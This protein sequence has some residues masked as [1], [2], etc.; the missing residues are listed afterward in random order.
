MFHC[1][2]RSLPNKHILCC[3]EKHFGEVFGRSPLLLNQIVYNCFVHSSAWVA[4]Q[5]SWFSI[6][7]EK[8]EA[9]FS[10]WNLIIFMKK[11]FAILISK[12]NVKALNLDNFRF[13]NLTMK[14]WKWIHPDDINLHRNDWI[15]SCPDF[16]ILYWNNWIWTCQENH[17]WLHIVRIYFIV[18]RIVLHPSS[19]RIFLYA[20]ISF[21]KLV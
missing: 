11:L 1:E 13:Q 16:R 2:S 6:T 20:S 5:L 21:Y 15:R 19:V 9:G 7:N 3:W 14:L 10:A 12:F 18:I 8:S 17:S 4:F